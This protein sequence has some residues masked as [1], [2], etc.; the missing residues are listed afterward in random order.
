MLGRRKLGEF[1]Q[2]NFKGWNDETVYGYVVKPYGY[3]PGRKFPDRLRGARRAA[4]QLPELL[5]L[6]LERPGV[7][8]RAAMAW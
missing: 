4:E 5:D 8:R 2:F 6:P 7:C 1:E 3:E